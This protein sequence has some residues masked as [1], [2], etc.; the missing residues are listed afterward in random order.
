M[1]SGRGSL[2]ARRLRSKS[3]LAL[4]M[5]RAA[6]ARGMR[7]GW[8]GAD[9]GYGK[10]P[11]FLRALED[12]G[13]V[14][15]ADV[16]CTQ[17]V[18]RE[19]PGLHVP[20]PKATRGRPPSRRRAATDDITVARLVAELRAKDWTRCILRDS[21]RGPL[22]VD[23]AH[24]RVWVWDGVEAAARCWHLIVRREVGAPGRIKFS[25]SNAAPETSPQR[26]AEMQGQR[27]WVERAFEDAKGECGLA[28]CQALGW[29][30]WHHHV[31]MVM[32]AM[33]FIAEQR[34]AHQPGLAL[35]TP[36]DIVEVLKQTLPAK[37]Q[38]KQALVDRINQRHARRRGAIQSRFRSQTRAAPS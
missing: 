8:V 36:R 32:L 38:S 29:R 35:L 20:V 25:L 33:L 34:V 11:A 17:R 18:W 13:E 26:L 30:A 22:T 27:Y 6:R 21:T 9:G 37:P 24:R 10:E 16:H 28:D 3:Q 31:T 4:E 5:V 15:L 12:A 2:P 19:P 1:R 7:F 14:F 23:I